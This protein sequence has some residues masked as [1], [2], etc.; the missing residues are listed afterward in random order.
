[1][2]C[3]TSVEAKHVEIIT[4]GRE[5]S[6]VGRADADSEGREASGRSGVLWLTVVISDG[7]LV[8]RN[9]VTQEDCEQRQTQSE[10]EISKARALSFNQRFSNL[11]HVRIASGRSLKIGAFWAAP[12]PPASCKAWRG[13]SPSG[14]ACS[15]AQVGPPN[16]HPPEAQG[17]PGAQGAV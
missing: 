9:T 5:G 17:G 12:H 11:A 4:G 13:R 14:H 8:R 1:M 3:M 2:G 6:E 7:L 10:T 15:R 16:T